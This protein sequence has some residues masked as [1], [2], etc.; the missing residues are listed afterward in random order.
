MTAWI[1]LGV[2]GFWTFLCWR[3]RVERGR[4]HRSKLEMLRRQIVDLQIVLANALYPA[5]QRANE[6]MRAFA[7]AYRA[8]RE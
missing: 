1:V 6:A 2:G 3:V 7:D 8:E 4:V 5:L